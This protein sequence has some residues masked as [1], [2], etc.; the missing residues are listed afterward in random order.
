MIVLKQKYRESPPLLF[1]IFLVLALKCPWVS[2]LIKK[3]WFS[4]VLYNY[5]IIKIAPKDCFIVLQFI[6]VCLTE[7]NV[8]GKE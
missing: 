4:I 2:E 6:L 7:K 5:R 8:S 3:T 1:F